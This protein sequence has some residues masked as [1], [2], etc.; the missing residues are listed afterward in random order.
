MLETGICKYATGVFQTDHAAEPPKRLIPTGVS[1]HQAI[2]I[3]LNPQK[4][5][6]VIFRDNFQTI[7]Y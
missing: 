3:S 4:F 7:F 1:N 6:D 5:L 2:E